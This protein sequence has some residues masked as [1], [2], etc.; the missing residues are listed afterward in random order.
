MYTVYTNMSLGK[1]GSW[2]WTGRPGELR[3][4]G[5]QRVGHDWVTELNWSVYSGS[6]DKVPTPNAGDL[7]SIPGLGRSPEESSGHPLQYSCL[8]NPMDGGAWWATVHGVA[9]TH[10]QL[11]D[12]TFFSFLSVYRPYRFLF[13]FLSGHPRM[14]RYLKESLKHKDNMQD[15]QSKLDNAWTHGDAGREVPG[16]SVE[17]LSP[18]PGLALYVTSLWMFLSYMLVE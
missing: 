13:S 7:G 8:E 12:F 11:S 17:A 14:N 18:S 10:T 16:E 5:S 9:K 15:K 4:V 1:L 6:D 2:W 3:F